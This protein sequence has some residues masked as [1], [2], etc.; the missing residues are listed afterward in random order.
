MKR[1]AVVIALEWVAVDSEL[2]TAAAY[3]NE[4]RQLYL[5][6]ADGNVYRYFACPLSDYRKFL[7]A[8]SKGRYFAQHIRNQF[9]HELVYRNE[10]TGGTYWNLEQQLSSSLQLAKARMAQKREAT[11]AAG[12]QE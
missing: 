12:V 1:M 2:F 8:E 9:R 4:A 5:R 7:A 11:Q 10:G 6:F 3:L